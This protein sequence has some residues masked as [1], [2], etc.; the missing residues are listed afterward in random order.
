VFYPRLCLPFSVGSR[1]VKR[2]PRVID[3]RRQAP[4]ERGRDTGSTDSAVTGADGRYVLR[5]VPQG[6]V[7][8]KVRRDGYADVL[9]P[10]FQLV[11]DTLRFSVQLHAAPPTRISA[12]NGRPEPI[13]AI[14]FAADSAEIRLGGAGNSVA[15]VPRDQLEAW[16]CS[17]WEPRTKE[18]AAGTV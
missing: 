17:Q 7:V 2:P 1:E 5:G 8:L 12:R 4:P 18:T 6:V 11:S 9:F 16:T 14:R 10:D 13:V 3:R 15:D